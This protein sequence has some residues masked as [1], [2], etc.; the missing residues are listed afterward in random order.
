MVT[1]LTNDRLNRILPPDQ[2]RCL[3]ITQPSANPHFRLV[4]GGQF[5]TGYID[6]INPISSNAHLCRSRWTNGKAM[7][8]QHPDARHP[9]F[10]LR[11]FQAIH[12]GDANSLNLR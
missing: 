12:W 4:P 7:P 6:C 5:P 3:L 2:Q 8:P 9:G 10:R 1:S 11:L